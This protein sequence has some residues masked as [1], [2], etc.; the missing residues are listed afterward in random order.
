MAAF[1]LETI[2][3]FHPTEDVDIEEAAIRFKANPMDNNNCLLLLALCAKEVNIEKVITKAKQQ[4]YKPLADDDDF[5]QEFAFRCIDAAE[6]YDPTF[7]SEKGQKTSFRSYVRCHITGRMRHIVRST[8]NGG[9]SQMDVKTVKKGEDKGKAVTKKT[10]SLNGIE[11]GGRCS[12]INR[13]ELVLDLRE[14]MNSLPKE[15]KNLLV[16]L[17]FGG[18]TYEEAME[19]FKLTKS[20]VRYAKKTALETLKKEYPSLREYLDDDEGE[21]MI[22][23]L[24]SDEDDEM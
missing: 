22:I 13:T 8:Y 18:H 11:L 12:R 1:N 23:Q 19:R 16:F 9:R 2:V 6:K 24:V 21:T 4:S 7:V 10:E 15:Q 17:F 14:A 3:R 5:F 20:Q